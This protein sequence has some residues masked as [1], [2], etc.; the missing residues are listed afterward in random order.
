MHG[1]FQSKS[2]LKRDMLLSAAEGTS[3]VTQGHAMEN[4]SLER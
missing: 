1:V 2:L 3:I 4:H